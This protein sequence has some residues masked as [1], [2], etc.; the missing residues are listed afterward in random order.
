MTLQT[1][2]AQQA[3]PTYDAVL[4][5]GVVKC[6]VHPGLIGFAKANSLGEYSGFDVDICRAIAAAVFNDADAVEYVAVNAVERFEAL[7][8]K[9]F[10]VLSRNSTW[11]SDRNIDFGNFVGVN[12]Y[13]GQGFMVQK[14]SGIRSAL[15]LDNV[16]ICVSRGTTTELNAIDFFKVT[17][18]RY[19]PI[20]KNSEVDTVSAYMSGECL[21]YTTDRSALAAQRTEFTNPDAHLVL[22]EVISKEPLGPI[23]RSDDARWENI[24][25]WSLN[26]MINAEELGVTSAN[27][28]QQSNATPAV[29][30]LVGLE[31]ESGAKMG[32]DNGWCGN[33]VRQVGNY[34]EIYEK[35]LGLNTPIGLPRGV[36]ALWTDGG[37]LYAAPIR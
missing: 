13:D 26:C 32:V 14:R 33:I 11:T 12:Y 24:A 31:G 15:E 6:G 23:V 2:A 8:N 34:G 20:Y 36:N 1:A 29:R 27:V 21:A 22:P 35:H 18:L 25:R 5:R 9:E 3:T 19:K 7:L 16:P 37:L 4:D 28:D 10:D 30:R 17:D